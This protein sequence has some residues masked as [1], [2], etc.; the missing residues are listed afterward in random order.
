MKE[1]AKILSVML[2]LCFSLTA[3]AQPHA[4]HLLVELLRNPLGIDKASP[5]LSWRILS[6]ERNVK[7]TAYRVLVA[8]SSAK[9]DRDEGDLW[10]SGQVVSDNSISVFY[11]GKPL[12]SDAEVFWKVKVY[13]NKGECDWSAPARWQVGLLYYKDWDKRWIGFDRYFNTDDQQAGY[14]SARYFRKEISLSKKVAKATA[15]IIGLGLYEFYIDGKKIGD[16]VL[17]PGLTDYTQN[18]MY[19]TF[20]VTEQLTGNNHALGVTLGN[21]RYYAVRQEKPYKVKDF[22]F[23]KMQLQIRITYTDG[24]KQTLYTDNTWKGTTD[25]PIRSNNEYDGEVYD[26]R[27]ELQGWASLGYDDT[28]WIAAEYVQEP[29]GKYE[30]Q[31]NRNMKVMQDIKPVSIRSEDGKYILDFGQNF[32]GWVKM[33]VQGVRGTE[34]TLRFAEALQEDGTLSRDNLRAAKATDTYILKGDDE[35]VWE[36]RFTYHGFRYVEVS[37]Y[38]GEADIDDF[39]GR[40]VYD[41]MET[42]GEFS[43]SNPLLNQIHKNAWWGIASNYKSIPVDCPQRNERQAW[44]GDRPTSAYGENFLFDNANF[45]VKWLEDIRLSQKTDGAIPDVAPAFWRYYSDNMTWPSAYPMIAD[46]LFRHTGDVRVLQDHYPS[47]KKWMDYMRAR[48]MND[49]GIITKDS[50][51]DWCAPPATIEAGRGKSADKKYPNPVLSTAYYYYLLQLMADF[52]V[53]MGN[54]RDRADFLQQATQIRKDFNLQFYNQ[55][56]GYGNNTLTENL[57]AMY[58]GLVEEGEKVKL[59]DRIVEIIEEENRGHLSTGVVG[60]QWIMRTLT[61]MGRSDLAFKLTTNKTYPSWGYMIEHGATTIWELWNGNTAHP[62]M[63]SENHVM[64][65]GDL[66]V[67]SYENLAGIKSKENGFQTIRMEPE[68]IDGLHSV[69]A[70]YRSL[71]GE[72]TSSWSK[73][74]SA[75]EWTVSIPANAKAEIYLP[76][77][78]LSAVTEKNKKLQDHKDIEVLS[79]E[80][81]KVKILAGSG[82]YHFKIKL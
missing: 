14:L 41:E 42:V 81:G 43:S 28:A 20:D 27:K 61:D 30:S 10:D 55:N 79:E 3:I 47:M 29:G 74:K 58:F 12:K 19:N 46:M 60:T 56:G 59:A 11:G 16:Q 22:G 18:V 17:A 73:S 15:Y 71:Y 24:S 63:N 76:T 66:L 48:Y 65:L 31:I 1:M 49:K 57:L 5:R 68:M 21:G 78:N 13:T 75:F 35:E 82:V 69:N 2:G 39:M 23:P 34:V 7:Q 53:H 26:A 72:I 45:Y 37:G 4:E 25:G 44:L 70:S 52:S 54:E 80:A 38:P 8:S 33:R 50:Y 51:G 62:Q 36:P 6:E 64:M 40:F 77:K 9:L 32:S 67:W